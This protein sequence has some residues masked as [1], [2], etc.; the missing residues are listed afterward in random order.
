MMW[1]AQ[2]GNKC[3]PDV[4]CARVIVA[5]D[6]RGPGARLVDCTPRDVGDHRHVVL[7][8]RPVKLGEERGQDDL[9][10]APVDGRDE[11]PMR[12]AHHTES[13][14]VRDR[15]A[16]CEPRAGGEHCSSEPRSIDSRRLR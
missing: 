9:V 8:Q 2:P 13:H 15:L 14:V 11:P 6:P 16:A 12:Q 5:T 3:G 4:P 7:E 1:C 10:I